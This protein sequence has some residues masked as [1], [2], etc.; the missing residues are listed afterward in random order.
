MKKVSVLAISLV[1]SI[2][3][4]QAQDTSENPSE[5]NPKHHEDHTNVKVVVIQES[6]QSPPRTPDEQPKK[7]NISPT[8]HDWTSE[9][10]AYSTL[11]IAFFT[12]VMAV[13]VVRQLYATYVTERA[14]FV[15]EME[16]PPGY[17]E[18]KMLRLAC[19]MKNMGETSAWVSAKGQSKR[20]LDKS[21]VLPTKPI[22]DEEENWSSKG[23]LL[24][25]NG[26]IYPI[27]YLVPGDARHVYNGDKTLWIYRYIKYRDIFRRRHE[28]RYCFRYYPQIGGEDPATCGFYPDGPPDYNEAT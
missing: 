12:I 13:T 28:T 6:P 18:G 9:V 8:P 14:L 1:L 25:P 23:L 15:A 20:L 26:T 4:S 21:V 7:N 22:Y 3:L 19:H 2:V 16:R 27:F 5:K 17:E 10:N 11:V 24:P